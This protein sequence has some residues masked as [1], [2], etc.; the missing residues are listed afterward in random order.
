MQ[1]FIITTIEN[2]T[3]VHYLRKRDKNLNTDF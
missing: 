1:F 2:L 3:K